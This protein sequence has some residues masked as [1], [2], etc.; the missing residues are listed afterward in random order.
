MFFYYLILFFGLFILLVVIPLREREISIKTVFRRL[1][2]KFRSRKKPESLLGAKNIYAITCTAGSSA[3]IHISKVY[4]FSLLCLLLGKRKRLKH[5]Q[6]E[7]DIINQHYDAINK[8]MHNSIHRLK[9]ES[10]ES[11]QFY[12][13]A[14]ENIR[15][16]TSAINAFSEMIFKLANNNT[17]SFVE[18]Q[19]KDF[20]QFNESMA[21]FFNLTIHVIKNQRFEKYKEIDEDFNNLLLE[22]EGLKKKQIKLI[23][24]GVITTQVSLEQM[25]L[26]S[27]ST[28]LVVAIKQLTSNI[29]QFDEL[30]YKLKEQQ[31][32]A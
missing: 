27:E 7:L 30:V 1:R 22:I 25:G 8:E 10:I 19:K 23:K 15:N 32:V 4:Y 28:N 6:G 9:E 31:Y 3:L 24:K 29:K 20:R 11:G 16:S 18:T 2:M 13:Q 21:Y 14:I 12:I 17:H 5:V 26:I